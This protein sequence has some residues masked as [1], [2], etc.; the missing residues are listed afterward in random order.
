MLISVV[1]PIFNEG[2]TISEL[3]RR[4]SAVMADL[5]EDYE[6]VYVNDGSRDSSG[7]QLREL[8]AADPHARL[9][10]FSRNFGHQIAITAGMDHARG[11]AVVVIDADLQDPPE[12]IPELVAKWRDGYDVVYAVRE[13]REGDS[14]FK[15][16]TA[17][18]F[19]RLIARITN[20]EIPV[21]TGDFRLMSRRAIE[22]LKL[23]R[24]RNRFVRGLV[25]WLGYRQTGVTFV[26]HERFAGETKYPLKKMLRFAFDGITSFSFLPL[27]L[28]MYLGFLVSFVSFLGVLYVVYLRLFTH[29]TILGWAS[30]MTAI[31]FLGGV[32]L[33]TLGIIGEYVGRIYDEAKGRPLYLTQDVL[34]FDREAG[35]RPS[36]KS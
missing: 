29:E 16:A 15:R 18:M 7:Q 13:R 6:L 24:E 32:Q 28:A 14:L 17:A 11:D 26:R 31:L 30:L 34:G 27:Q 33:I 36:L 22:G 23:I 3:H 8:V 21:D 19:Y 12:L 1:V 25:A 2:A 9:I 35:N 10:D 5:P 4:L 20:V